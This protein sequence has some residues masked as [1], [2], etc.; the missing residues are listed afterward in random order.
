MSDGSSAPHVGA[1]EPDASAPAPDDGT[2]SDTNTSDAATSDTNR[3]DTTT[4]KREQKPVVQAVRWTVIATIARQGLQVVG[5]IVLAR[6]L[7]PDVYGVI[8]LAT[9]YTV[10]AALILDQGLAA[11][12]IQRPSLLKD[13]PGAV[14]TLNLILAGVLAAATWLLAPFLE[15]FFS[16]P[17]LS[18]VLRLLAVGLVLKAVVI[19]P[20]AVLTRNLNFKMIGKADIAGAIVGTTAGIAAALL[21][22][23]AYSVVFL[24]VATDITAMLVIVLWAPFYPPN[25]HFRL[26]GPILPYS[27]RVFGT[28]VIA[29][30][31]RNTDNVLVG[32]YFGVAELSFYAMAYRVLAIPVQMIGQTSAR[33]MFPL[34]AGEAG[35]RE[36]LSRHLYRCTQ[37]LAAVTIPIMVWVSCASEELVLLVLGPAWHTTA[38]ILSIFAL[39]GAREA[40]FYVT[41]SLMKA[42][43]HAALNL[44][45]EIF[46]T[47]MQV[48]G[49]VIGLQFGL[50]GVA[51][52][53][54]IAGLLI[55]PVLMLIQRRLAGLGL[56]QQ[57]KALTPPI[58]CGAAGA[59]GYLLVAWLGSSTLTVLLAGT[60]AYLVLFAGCA[61]VFFP[62][63]KQEMWQFA[64]RFALSRK[65]S[66]V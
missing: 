22:A 48:S 3:S 32:R 64:E 59:A 40:I 21:G 60:I 25:L 4:V 23:G 65:K 66:T 54:A 15:T 49:I 47:L 28:N 39:A 18:G 38:A 45:F 56:L 8:S 58:V 12:L 26:L 44:R 7:G 46:S 10:I 52:G 20:R 43:G 34:F 14:A 62:R 29:A 42:T 41:P 27:L 33:F 13:L 61:L 1:R 37:V 36:A 53:Y 19:V 31:S 16:A 57:L 55:T 24:T 17:P 63:W 9:L 30:F 6:M 50:I 2:P 51:A 5:A 35:S 11:A